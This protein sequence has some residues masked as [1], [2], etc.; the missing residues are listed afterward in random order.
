MRPNNQLVFSSMDPKLEIA[1]NIE[2]YDEDFVAWVNAKADKSDDL[3]ERAAL[4]S[5]SEIIDEVLVAFLF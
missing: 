3:E 4:K 2:F 5:L 1:R